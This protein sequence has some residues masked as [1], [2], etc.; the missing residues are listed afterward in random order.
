MLKSDVVRYAHRD[1]MPC[2]VMSSLM[3]AVMRCVPSRAV[4]THHV[5]RTHHAVRRITFPKGTHR[6]QKKK[7]F[8]R[9]A[10]LLEVSQLTSR[11]VV[12]LRL[13]ASLTLGSPHALLCG[14]K[15]RRKRYSIVF[16]SF[17]D[18]NHRASSIGSDLW[19]AAPKQKCTRL[20]AFLFWR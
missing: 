16:V 11:I 15:L 4:G 17:S 3:L 7:H 10:F 2:I 18:S 6:F 20:G 13:D 1:V 5:R 14:E 12:C 19:S 9:S 8:F